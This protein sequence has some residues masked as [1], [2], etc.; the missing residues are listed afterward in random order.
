[1]N[2]YRI[3]FKNGQQTRLR[4]D[5]FYLDESIRVWIK[6]AGESVKRMYDA[7]QVRKVIKVGN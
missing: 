1:M 5:N 6:V 3:I 2:Q 7:W 4:A